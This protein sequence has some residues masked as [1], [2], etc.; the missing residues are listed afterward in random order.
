[1]RPARLLLASA[2]LFA[3][4]ACAGLP[5][6]GGEASEGG[7]AS[8]GGGGA[9]TAAAASGAVPDGVVRMKA[10]VIEDTQGYAQPVPA[11]RFLVPSDWTVEGGVEWTSGAGCPENAVR[12]WARA[13]APDGVTTF[14]VLP[15][16]TWLWS[17][18]P[19]NQ[20]QLASTA[21][22]G[23]GCPLM[24][25][26]GMEGWVREVFVPQRRPGSS[27][28][29]SEALPGLVAH[30]EGVWAP[31]LQQARAAGMPMRYQADA[32]RVLLDHGASEEWITGQVE[33][34]VMP[35]ASLSAGWSGNYSATTDLETNRVSN[36]FAGRAPK[37]QLSEREALFGTIAASYRVDPRWLAAVTQLV[38]GIKQGQID[39]YKEIARIHRETSQEILRSNQ[40]SWEA[41]QR[42]NDEAAKSF[43]QMIRE[44]DEWQDTDGGTVE[45]DQNWDHAWSNGQGEYLLSNDANWQPNVAL[46]T[47]EWTQLERAR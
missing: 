1:M 26:M 25:T 20:Q 7:S 6:L 45:L 47:T 16:M 44:V 37:G 31:R 5:D 28:V 4:L 21:Q 14:E 41:T 39:T 34:V 46:G 24:P 38:Q 12:P 11:F 13:T 27:L 43:S 9:G 22:Q 23:M 3:L 30:L 2:G 18:D 33:L 15:A 36:L 42:S 19:M 29:R 10:A 32:A 17:P 8:A 40:A 35:M